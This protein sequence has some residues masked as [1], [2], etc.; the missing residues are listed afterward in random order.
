MIGFR[1]V[2]QR[3]IL[4]AFETI[5]FQDLDYGEVEPNF[6]EEFEEELDDEWEIINPN[7]SSNFV[8]FNENLIRPMLTTG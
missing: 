5:H 3:P 2:L 7:G 6:V 1:R 4:G 8:T